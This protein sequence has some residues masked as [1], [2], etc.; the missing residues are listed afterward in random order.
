MKKLALVITLLLIS[1]TLLEPISIVKANPSPIIEWKGWS[2]DS[3]AVT[4]GFVGDTIRADIRMNDE[5]S[6][7]YRIRI[8]RDID[9][10]PDE[11]MTVLFF[12]YDGGD[13]TYSLSFTPDIGTGEQNTN[14]YHVDVYK[15]EWWGWDEKWTMQNEYPP[16]LRVI[17]WSSYHSYGEIESGLRSLER[18]IGKVQSIGVS[19]EGRQIWAIKISD[20]PDTNDKT[21]PDILF[22]GC[23]HAR[24]WIS[25]EVPLYIAANFVQRYGTD[26]NVRTLIDNSEIWI[27]PVL[28]P[29][30]F[31]YSHSS[32]L[33]RLWRKN[34]RDNGDGT[35]GVDI[36]RNYGYQWGLDSGSSGSSD[37]DVYRGP[38]AFSEPETIAMRDLI[39]SSNYEFHALITYHSYSQLVLYPWGYTN[40][41]APNSG[42]MNVLATEMAD[43]IH[44]VHGVTY[45]PQ[46]SSQLYLTSGDLTDWAYGTKEIPSFT[47]EMRP[48]SAVPGFL[49]PENEILPTCEENLPAASYLARW[50]VLS[51]GGFM[52]F[53]NGVDQLPIRS[54]IP[55]MSFTTTMGYDWVY[56][57]I[58]T[59]QYNVNPYGSCYYECHGNFFAWLGPNQGSGRI[60]FVGATAESVSML[61][62]TYYGTHLDAYDSSGNLVASDYAGSNTQ[63]GT[64][65]EVAVSS[66]SIAYV[67]VH[68]T[69]NYW[70]IDDLRV[71]DLLRETNAF[72]PP[73]STN[74]FQTL[75]TIGEGDVF[76]YEFTNS[77]QQILKILLNWQGS[78]FGIQV[79]RPNGTMLCETESDN[80]PI[81]IVI[82]AAEAG[83][84]RITVTALD[85]PFD[86]YPF[87]LDVASPPL[88]ADNTPP[89]TTLTIGEPKYISNKTYV[90][91]DTPFT[92]EATDTES[93]VY[94]TAYRIYNTAYNSGWQTYTAPFHLTSLTDGAYIIEYNSTDN[95]G[96]TEQTNTVTVVLGFVNASIAFDYDALNLK[97]IGDWFIAYIELP[98]GYD[99][100]GID[101]S[102]IML[103]GTIPA[104]LEPTAVGDHD[105]DGIPDLAVRFNRT[106][107]VEYL[108][109]NN[110]T[111]GNA[112]LTITGLST[113]E[114]EPIHRVITVAFEGSN[115]IKVSSLVGDVNC[116]G[117][118]NLFDVITALASYG[119]QEGDANWNPNANFAPS[120]ERINIFDIVTLIAHY[121]EKSP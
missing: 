90:T 13:Q 108:I 59:G 12:D 42:E 25:A 117:T 6:G 107:L 2:I 30:G 5:P 46:Q 116:D 58:R 49:L 18:G 53:E 56:G 51:Q 114:T 17:G 89:T 24:E 98:E 72:Q 54:T 121:G 102:T 31:E 79:F 109:S 99:V 112:T 20:D 21:E 63:T 37:A 40:E 47:I 110:I 7:H 91:P 44:G 1:A 14:G 120:W 45:T 26:S 4:V 94:S 80:P 39:S 38:Y 97:S 61:T 60:D 119:S 43:L 32:P 115:D 111:S 36:N 8:M 84:W 83:T 103:N 29:D 23:H 41:P 77:Q 105:S 104:E 92:L 118:V 93:G 34:R 9:T 28:N 16:R 15:D 62:S 100:N 50:V 86:D 73:D 19:V 55:G 88:P 66:S 87:A 27:V 52:D 64:M 95:I 82:P 106:L 3:Y 33:N 22:V 101:V 57:D 71:R 10:W 65:S 76:T 81:R 11:E 68:D 48:S 96:N 69:G 75:D 35:F 67:I 85:V 70:L 74:V 113:Q 78:Q